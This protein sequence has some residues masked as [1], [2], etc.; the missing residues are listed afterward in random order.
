LID[1]IAKQARLCN[2]EMFLLKLFIIDPSALLIDSSQGLHQDTDIVVSPKNMLKVLHCLLLQF[3][4]NFIHLRSC[5][6][7]LADKVVEGTQTAIAA[8]NSLLLKVHILSMIVLY[9]HS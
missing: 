2:L 8:E 5:E 3:A 9:N 1:D 4:A 7:L 6:L